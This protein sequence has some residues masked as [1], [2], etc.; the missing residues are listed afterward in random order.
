MKRKIALALLAAILVTMCMA[1]FCAC[2]NRKPREVEIEIINPLTGKVFEQ[3]EILELPTEQTPIEVKIKN[4]RGKYLT[5][6]NLSDSTVEESIS[7]KVS[8]L[9]KSNY[10]EVLNTDGYLPIEQENVVASNY[11]EIEVTFD[12][13][14][15]NSDE[16]YKRK[17]QETTTSVRFYSNKEWKGTDYFELAFDEW[18]MKGEA[19]FED[20]IDDE[21][22]L[23]RLLNGGVW[24]DLP[25]LR[26][27]IDTM[28]ELD[29]LRNKKEYPFFNE[30]HSY[31]KI[32]V[33]MQQL[34]KFNEDYF[35]E[36][37]LL[38]IMQSKGSPDFY[39]LGCLFIQEETVTV[40]FVQPQGDYGT[41][42]VVSVKVSV[43]EVDKQVI[44]N[45]E[46]VKLEELQRR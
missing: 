26:E 10:K 13:K 34:D 38:I 30:R 43:I 36:K 4:K 28:E 16:E 18:D 35:K 40:K 5:D 20:E 41:P 9:W 17:Y 6:K 39:D 22:Y 25:D 32:Y 14:P 19:V 23:D 44:K 8:R 11:Y 12:C 31:M 42:A 24:K 1:M 15:A 29:S 2:S 37:F 33:A 3:D 7:I 27:K 46:Q 45:V 21:D